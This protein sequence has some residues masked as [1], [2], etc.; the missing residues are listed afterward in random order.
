MVKQPSVKFS[1]SVMVM[2]IVIISCLFKNLTNR[3][4]CLFVY[5]SSLPFNSASDS[6]PTSHLYMGLSC[7]VDYKTLS[8]RHYLLWYTPISRH[9]RPAYQ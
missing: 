2:K 5:V 6:A 4:V 8:G 9:T 1:I 7:N 3:R